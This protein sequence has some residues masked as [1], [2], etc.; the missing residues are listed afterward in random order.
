MDSGEVQTGMVF[1]EEL[2]K[3]R[4]K[5]TGESVH[6]GSFSALEKRNG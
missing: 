2:Q 5:W 4:A 6:G 3:I 1:E